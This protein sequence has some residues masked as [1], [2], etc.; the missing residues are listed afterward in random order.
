MT[1]GN[2]SGGVSDDLSRSVNGNVNVNGDRFVLM[3]SFQAIYATRSIAQAA[4][5]VGLTQSAV[6]KHLVKL[7]DWLGDELFVRTH[8]GMQP[9][10]HAVDLSDRIDKLLDGFESLTQN[11]CFDIAKLNA[12]YVI[13]TT[14]EISRRLLPKLLAVLNEAA[15]KLKVSCITLTDDYALERLELGEVD[16]VVSVNWLAPEQLIQRRLY[17]ERFVC[18]M[19]Q[20]H[21][22]AGITLNLD[23]YLSSEHLMVA[24]FG[25][26]SN[27]IDTFLQEK[28]Q[29]RC[30]RATVA[31]F[32]NINSELLSDRYIITLPSRVAEDLKKSY[33]C[34]KNIV[35]KPL[36][37]EWPEFNYFMFWHRRFNNEQLGM[38]MR[39]VIGKILC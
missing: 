34:D 9:T 8:S 38:W 4:S 15:P 20:D 14:D 29:C 25:R 7:R 21:P 18:V 24:P 23:D 3:R 36:P 35:I 33:L 28:G 12:R 11:L 26:G 16:L 37:F 27:Q 1:N 17:S 2:V 30:V 32:S 22:L 31:C 19:T 6:S 10:P 39:E 13:A 5:R